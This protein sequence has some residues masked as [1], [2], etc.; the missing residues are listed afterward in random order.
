MRTST[1]TDKLAAALAKAQAE[2]QNPTRN[3]K[4]VVKTAKGQ[5]DY[6]YATADKIADLV[7]PVLGK[8]ELSLA[9]GTAKG[10]GWLL[11]T[12]LTH[13]S[14]QYIENDTPLPY[15][16]STDA[17]SLGSALTYAKR[18]GLTALLGIVAEEDDD[19]AGAAKRS[20]G[21]VK[22]D[23]HLEGWRKK[24]ADAGA[25]SAITAVWGEM[26]EQYRKIL[27]SDMT[28]ARKRVREAEAAA[29]AA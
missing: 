18:Y 4:V 19:G 11:V 7:R 3:R 10:D 12:R 28:A 5:Y 25:M 21:E 14:G 2:L 20:N 13:A 15:S 27:T 24:L 9:Q 22:A 23:P 6:T 29:G 16:G 8:H 26:P 1:E 17:Q